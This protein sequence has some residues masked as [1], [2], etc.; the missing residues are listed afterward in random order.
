MGQ[1]VYARLPP[2]E[3]TFEDCANSTVLIRRRETL[4][5]GRGVRSRAYPHLCHTL[6]LWAWRPCLSN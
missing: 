2:I 4:A 1:G 5:K 6:L 3:Q